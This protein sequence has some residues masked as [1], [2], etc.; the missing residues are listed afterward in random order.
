[1]DV[2]VELGFAARTR[3]GGGEAALSVLSD[4]ESATKDE[5]HKIICFVIEVHEDKLQMMLGFAHAI[6]CRGW[7][8]R[9]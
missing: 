5:L 3:G 2:V 1:L 4:Q 8:Q 6:A 9:D 7:S